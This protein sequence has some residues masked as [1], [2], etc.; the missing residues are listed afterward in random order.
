MRLRLLII[1]TAL[2]TS[3]S[4]LVPSCHFLSLL[5]TSCFLVLSCPPPDVEEWTQMISK[6]L[7]AMSSHAGVVTYS[8]GREQR[9]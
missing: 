7:P 3:L 4:L 8:Q 1:L 9:E 2:V 5:V 6:E